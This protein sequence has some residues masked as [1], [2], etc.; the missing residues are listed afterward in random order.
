MGVRM[1][2]SPVGREWLRQLGLSDFTSVMKFRAGTTVSRHKHRDTVTLYAGQDRGA[3]Q[4]YLK[5]VYRVP[6]KHVLEDLVRG[7]LPTSQPL[8]EWNA[9][10]QCRQRGINVMQGLAW[11]QRSVL[12][13]PRQAFILVEAVPAVE[14]V[15]DALR[16]LCEA[17]SQ[18]RAAPE[19]RRLARELGAFLSRLH[20]SGLVW[21][22]SVAKHIY[23]APHAPPDPQQRYVFHLIDVERMTTGGTARDRV[24]D[25]RTFYRSIREYPLAATDLLRFAKAYAGLDGG[26]W[27]RDRPRLVALFDWAGRILRDTRDA[28]RRRPTMPDDAQPPYQRR[29]LRAHRVV[30]NEAFIPVLQENGLAR[31]ASVFKDDRGERLNKANIGSWRE[32][33]RTVLSESTGRRETLYLKRYERPPW[34]EQLLRI[35]LRGAEHSTA[36]WEWRNIRRLVEAGVPT[37]TPV[38]FGERMRGPFERQS[39][40]VTQAI[41]GVSLEQ[42]VPEHLR[43]GGDVGPAK[44][45]AIVGQLA[46]LVR[47]LHEAGFVHRD[48][49]LS[50]IFI[51]HNRDGR[52]ALRLIDLQRVFR[53]RWRWRRWQV[54]DL[55]AL[56][57]STPPACVPATERIRFMRQYL[58]VPRLRSEDKQLI[59][60]ILAKTRRIERHNR[61]R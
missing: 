52:P 35:L 49:Y 54:K 11:A 45:R 53:P 29:F 23:L 12:G 59:R 43:P 33:R 48:L 27:R 46:L 57:Y 42:F 36:W 47:T 61:R 50:H 18:E 56:H 10:E 32:R 16:R 25:L 60:R 58:D 51:S 26:R 40:V 30:V 17:G 31:F 22:D 5:R 20:G 8:R 4:F 21:P 37:V 55:A 14:N 41:P 3:A 34:R 28:H 19:R 2:V 15:D 38:A 9:I 6:L 24:E 39:F 44:R 7:R 13:V 1:H